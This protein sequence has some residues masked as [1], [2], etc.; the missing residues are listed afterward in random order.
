[1]A[2]NTHGLNKYGCSFVN[3][4]CYFDGTKCTSGADLTAINCTSNFPSKAVCIKIT[5]LGV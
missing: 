3:A 5:T 2:C 4:E 1:M